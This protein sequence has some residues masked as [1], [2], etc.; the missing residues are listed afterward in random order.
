[1][2]LDDKALLFCKAAHSAI[3]QLRKYTFEPYWH[4]PYDVAQILKTH[5]KNAVS[6][7]QI[8]A[9]YLHDVLEDTK[10]TKDILESEFGPIVTGL[11]LDV[12]N[13]AQPSDGNRKTRKAINIEHLKMASPEAKTIKCADI[14][15]NISSIVDYDPDFAEVYLREKEEAAKVLT[16]ADPGL[17]ELMINKI[18]EGRNRLYKY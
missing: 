10:V 2:T 13:I 15:H 7:E 8:A 5:A 14:I 16:E 9:A 17:Y 11:V 1:M 4:H 3:G 6:I 12:T 18:T